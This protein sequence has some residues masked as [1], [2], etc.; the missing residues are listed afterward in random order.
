MAFKN[1]AIL[2]YNVP[3]WKNLGLAVPNFG[4]DVA[5]NN[6]SCLYLVDAIGSN[7]QSL[8]FHVDA[9]LKSPP[10]INT[11]R[12]VHMLC[13]RARDILAGRAIGPAKIGMESDHNAPAPEVFRVYPTP[14]FLVRNR[15]LKE[16]AGYMLL[17]QAEIIQNSENARAFEISTDLSGRIGQYVQRVYKLM[18]TELFQIPAD[19]ADTPTFR[20]TDAQLAAY[21][22]AAFFSRTEM[23]DT[24]P[25]FE[26]QPTEDDIA[27]LVAGIPVTN[28]PQLGPYPPN[29]L[30][31][32]GNASQA[33]GAAPE[34]GNTSATPTS[35]ATN[36]FAPAPGA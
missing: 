31:S 15:W 14:Y 19:Q 33:N 2:W 29:G 36:A 20:L 26:N 35:T 21:N 30:T 16:W 12:R 6:L 3:T 25:S 10:T 9:R 27:P 34:A 22:P 13:N 5:S 1:D 18:A 8:M 17:A 28:L 4:D 24:V 7:L 11:L 23:T 32:T